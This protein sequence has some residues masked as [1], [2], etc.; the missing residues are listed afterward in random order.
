MSTSTK[1]YRKANIS[2]KKFDPRRAIVGYNAAAEHIGVSRSTLINATM[3]GR[4]SPV[5]YAQTGLRG[6]PP[7]VFTRAELN[8]LKRSFG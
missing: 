2:G 5:A 1:Q 8:E 6:R 3:A 4:I 7:V